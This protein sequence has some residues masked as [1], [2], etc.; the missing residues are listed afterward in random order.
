MMDYN[1]LKFVRDIIPG[2]CG[3]DLAYGKAAEILFWRECEGVELFAQD[4]FD[5]YGDLGCRERVKVLYMP[6]SGEAKDSS[7]YNHLLDIAEACACYHRQNVHGDD[8]NDRINILEVGL[9]DEEI[10]WAKSAW[11][12]G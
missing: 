2:A 5:F 10:E 3:V 6:Y 12:G 4:H 11:W 7:V 9:S 1:F 8:W